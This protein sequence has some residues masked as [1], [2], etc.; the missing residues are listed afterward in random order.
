MSY[1]LD[2]VKQKMNEYGIQDYQVEPILKITA[3]NTIGQITESNDY[4][5]LLNVFSSGN[6]IDAIVRSADNA[7]ILT[8][9]VAQT[10]FYK[11]QLFFGEIK[12]ENTSQDSLYLEFLRITPITKGC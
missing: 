3:T 2:I 1:A 9:A 7:I 10:E 6:D 4:H 5:L 12:I 8:P 11:I